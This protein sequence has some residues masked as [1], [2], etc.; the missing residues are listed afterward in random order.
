M[1]DLKNVPTPEHDA[2]DDK[3]FVCA[4]VQDPFAA[5]PPELRPKSKPTM[6]GLRKVT[7][8]GCGL[9]YWTNRV[10]DLCVDCEKKGV[11]LPRTDTAQE[12]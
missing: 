2:S 8:P 10:T 12:E 6:G 4:C 5:L 3:P 1:D 7:C 9:A 11:K